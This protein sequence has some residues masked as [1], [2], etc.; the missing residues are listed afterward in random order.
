MV[1]SFLSLLKWLELMSVAYFFCS[2]GRH[3]A[4]NLLKGLLAHLVLNYDVKLE[5][6]GVRP[7]NMWADGSLVPNQTAEV[8]FRKRQ[9]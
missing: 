9:F 4:A 2:P 6:D 8:M 5:N 1:C 3:F 7:T